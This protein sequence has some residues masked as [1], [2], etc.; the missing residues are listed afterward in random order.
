ML[1]NMDCRVSRKVLFDAGGGGGDDGGH[2][3][4]CCGATL[5]V[6]VG[7]ALAAI[8]VVTALAVDEYKVGHKT[9][10]SMEINKTATR[11]DLM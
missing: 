8:G 11:G 1:G 4:G 9:A 3:S 5:L 7:V 10:E 6:E 2:G